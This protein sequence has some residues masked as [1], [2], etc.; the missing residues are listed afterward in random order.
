MANVFYKGVPVNKAILVRHTPKDE[1]N[2]TQ[3]N[4][5]GAIAINN[6]N[7]KLADDYICRED[8]WELKSD[9]DRSL[10]NDDLKQFDYWQNQS[11]LSQGLDYISRMGNF[12]TKGIERQ[13]DATLWNQYGPVNRLELEKEMLNSGGAYI[14]SIVTVDRKY[15]HQLGIVT[16]QDFQ[17]LIRASWTDNASLWESRLT[18]RKMFDSRDDV[19][20]VAAYH[21]DADRNI[22]VHIHTWNARGTIQAGDTISPSSTRLGKE[23]ILQVGYNNIK[24]ERNARGDFLRDLQTAEIKHQLGLNVSE[25]E[26]QRLSFKA[27]KNE[28]KEKLSEKIDLNEKG[29]K[30]AQ[31][32]INDLKKEISEG[33]GRISNNKEIQKLSEQLVQCVKENS[34]TVK[35]LYQKN[36]E[37]FLVKAGIKGYLYNEEKEETSMKEWQKKQLESYLESENKE[38]LSRSTNKIIRDLLPSK[39]ANVELRKDLQNL[40]C[41]KVD[42][43]E[44]ISFSKKLTDYAI[45]QNPSL[46]NTHEV[47]VK[48]PLSSPNNP[49]FVK[50]NCNDIGEINKGQAYLAKI[51]LDKQYPLHN[52]N[53]NR[54]RSV[55]GKQLLQFYKKANMGMIKKLNPEITEELTQ[56]EKRRDNFKK[57]TQEIK[58]SI[59]QKTYNNLSKTQFD[60]INDFSIKH[61]LSLQN[62]MNLQHNIAKAVDTIQQAQKSENSLDRLEKQSQS[63]IELAV[64]ESFKSDDIRSCIDDYS[65]T[66]SER[67]GWS[68]DAIKD[69]IVNVMAKENVE[70]TKELLTENILD[71]TTSKYEL[72]EGAFDLSLNNDKNISQ[73]QSNHSMSEE[74]GGLLASL[75][76]CCGQS[77]FKG[78]R[79]N[80][81]SNLDEEQKRDFAHEQGRSLSR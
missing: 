72:K 81:R 55:E 50:L 54:I 73:D 34:E 16:K 25:D 70:F 26:K 22:H 39:E 38:L 14:D 36:Q 64:K 7:L 29:M 79:M 56:K 67:T 19:R 42:N 2:P 47:Y 33:R 20:W 65:K 46:K 24:I 78:K 49:Q 13:F 31:S 15:A 77:S 66:L 63:Y 32:L 41:S 23:E 21:T 18:H 30:E 44:N 12:E 60:R 45:N 68:Q 59:Q 37:M 74:M 71:Q 1:R 28:F 17:R 58:E 51:E 76:Q 62:T 5:N 3:K 4:N 40:D 53:G 27:E 43:S 35:T 61:G 48:T 6:F 9:I 69:E 52:S 75:A 8:D 11:K 57:R 80:F 10:T